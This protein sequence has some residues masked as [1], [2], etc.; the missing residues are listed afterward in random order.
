LVYLAQAL[1][2]GWFGFQLGD[3]TLQTGEYLWVWQLGLRASLACLGAVAILV[4]AAPFG[5][6]RRAGGW[7]RTAQG[8][9]LFFVALALFSMQYFN[10][11]TLDPTIALLAV[12]VGA[13]GAWILLRPGEDPPLAA[14]LGRWAAQG[15]GCALPW[16][17]A[18]A[19]AAVMV[20]SWRVLYQDQPVVTDS[21]SQ[22]AQARLLLAGHWR[23][24]VPQALR[25][26][27]CFPYAVKLA[28]SY[29]QYPPGYILPLMGVIGLKLPPQ[30]LDVLTAALIFSTYWVSAA[31]S[32]VTAIS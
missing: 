24:A 18:G 12:G 27:I 4:L 2:Q 13:L 19:G 32:G 15:G 11:A 17:A 7:L 22:I 6:A 8:G 9:G 25:D 31:A 5:G 29:S 1:H 21:Q 14:R 10:N 30:A 26:V 28:P 20:Y 23:L 3:L 16:L